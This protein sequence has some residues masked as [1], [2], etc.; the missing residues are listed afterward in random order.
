MKEE[1]KKLIEQQ[2]TYKEECFE[3][4]N[5]LLKINR[6][7]LSDEEKSL[8]KDSVLLLEKEIELRLVFINELEKLC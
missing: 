6:E 5:E 7:K 1:I 4:A 3:Q 2:K 8:L